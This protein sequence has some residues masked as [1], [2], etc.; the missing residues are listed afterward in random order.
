[1]AL[2]TNRSWPG[3]GL[4]YETAYGYDALGRT[5]S[6]TTADGSVATT[7][8]TG[9][10]ATITDPAKHAR[11]T[12]TNALGQL[13]AV[14][15][16]PGGYSYETTYGYDVLDDLTGVAQGS[17]TRNFN[18]DSLKRL[19]S[20]V[21]PE[22]G[23]TSYTY[24]GVGNL[25]TKTDA[26][27]TKTSY[28]YDALNRVTQKSYS[29]GYTS[30]VN[31]Q[32]DAAGA[33]YSWGH[34]TQVSNGNSTTNYV[35]IDP[36]GRVTASNQV[37]AGQTYGF[38]Y[39]YNL[40]GALTKE[41]YPSGRVVTTS[42]DGANR[43][44]E[45]AGSYNSVG[46]T[47][48][49]EV[50][51]FPH[52]GTQYTEYG[53]NLWRTGYY[54]S[55]LQ[56]TGLVDAI[57]NSPSGYLFLEYPIQ[58]GATPATNN[59]NVQALWEMVGN[60]V[61]WG[62]LTTYSETFVYDNLNRLTSATDSGGWTRSFGYDQYGNGW[63]TG[64]T[65]MGLSLMAPTSGGLFNSKNQIG[66]SPYDAAGNMLALPPGMSFA[67]DA[68]NR[69]MTESNSG[70]LSATYYYDGVG[71]RVEKVLSN[72]QKMVYVYD[73]LGR[74][75]AEYD[76]LNSEGPP[77]CTT[78]YFSYD[79]LGS[80]RMVTD[81]NANVIARHD[82]VPFGE[83]IPTGIAGRSGQFDVPDTVSQRFTGKERDTET[84]LDYFG[85]RY[86]GA[87]MERWMSPDEFKDSGI[88]DPSTGKVLFSPGPLPYADIE[89]PQSLNK[90]AYVLDNPLRYTDPTGHCPECLVWGSELLDSPAAQDAESWIS[91]NG[92]Q[93]LAGMGTL[94]AG[95][96][97]AL[98]NN[99]PTAFGGYPGVPEATFAAR[100]DQ[101]QTQPTRGEAL[102]QAKNDAGVPTSQQ[103]SKQASVPLTDSSG[104]PV[105]IDG[106]KQNTRE[107]T[108]TTGSGDTVVI[109]DHS[110]GHT[111]PDGGQV[112]PHFN[113]RPA[114]NT[115]N[116]SVPGTKPHY[117]YKKPGDEQ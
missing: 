88:T 52:G 27:N 9:Y 19:T 68:E 45:V 51:Y 58:Y 71:Q 12:A 4:S 21:Q 46:T 22:S 99:P 66:S 95:M 98:A 62:G 44:N 75:A 34:L 42:Y 23:T 100:P 74:L 115:R 57:G 103:P 39:Y 94:V 90:Y 97:A 64:W 2:A 93:I 91:S 5:T 17:E 113:V 105:I 28:S 84:S 60:D 49:P 1:V 59:G 72:S 18:Y 96:G 16:D 79:H 86:Y 56:V 43:A 65:G 104:K 40:A 15:E 63:V 20:S 6:V 24:D 7:S 35:S 107:Y 73:A 11:V 70:G 10:F 32:Y 48:V 53:N 38:T 61:A 26:R 78:C 30:T 116:G 77:P 55:R 69:Q 101:V 82:Y 13:A 102:N 106:Q 114:D 67:Y 50:T 3:D 89:N 112:G 36:L 92:S 33:G 41:T 47:Y 111:F 109:Q 117:P 29:D 14:W 80:L 37:T 81:Q 54:N 83:E 8:Y 87:G 25:L 110:Q 76:L 85:A 108:H 31:Y